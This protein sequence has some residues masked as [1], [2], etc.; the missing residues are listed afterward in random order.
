MDV[1][2]SETVPGTYKPVN[3]GA[4][5]EITDII[6]FICKTKCFIQF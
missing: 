4:L 2:M 3:K 1:K 6:E 5:Y